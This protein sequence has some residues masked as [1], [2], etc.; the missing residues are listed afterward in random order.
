MGLK[1]YCCFPSYSSRAIHGKCFCDNYI[2]LCGSN[3]SSYC[4]VPFGGSCDNMLEICHASETHEDTAG[5]CRNHS[6]FCGRVIGGLLSNGQIDE[7]RD[8]LNWVNDF[9]VPFP[10]YNQYIGFIPY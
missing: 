8:L 7:K 1:L 6:V 10:F 2:Y 5:G 9:I 4:C 3:T